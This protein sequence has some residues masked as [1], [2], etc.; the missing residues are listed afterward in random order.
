[1]NTHFEH[2]RTVHEHRQSE[3]NYP[4]QGTLLKKKHKTFFFC[5]TKIY[6]KMPPPVTSMYT[7]FIF[8]LVFFII[9]YHHLHIFSGSVSIEDQH[10]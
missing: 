1:M 5:P 10:G 8:L 2:Q 7:K 6:L 4:T 9:I 3:I